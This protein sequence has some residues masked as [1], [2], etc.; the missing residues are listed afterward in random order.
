MDYEIQN[1]DNTRQGG[2][3]FCPLLRQQCLKERCAWWTRDWHEERNRYNVDC[4]VTLIATGIND[5]SLH[6]IKTR[7]TI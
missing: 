5:E 2:G 4:A 7:K 1:E 6:R 3:K